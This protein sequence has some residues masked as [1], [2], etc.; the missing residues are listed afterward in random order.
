MKTRI[1]A[2]VSVI[3][4][5]AFTGTSFGYTSETTVFIDEVIVP[6]AG[7]PRFVIPVPS[8]PGDAV[9][10]NTKAVIDYSNA[11]DGY[12]MVKFTQNTRKA[13]RVIVKGPSGVSYTYIIKPGD[14]EVFPFSDGNGSYTVG[15]YE[16]AEGTKYAVANTV[17]ITVRLPNEFAP[18]LTPNQYVNFN[19]NNL[20]V[21]KAAELTNGS[22]NL[23]EKITAIYNFVIGNI[24][25]DK[26]LARTVQSG[27]L[28]DVDAVMKSKKGICFD[29]SAV[30]AAM[31]RSLG[32]PSK[33]VVGYAGEA[34]HA[35]INAY[36]K[37]TG[38]IN[39]VIFFD[40][41][42]WKLMD[43]TF[44]SSSKQSSEIMKFIGDGRNYKAKFMY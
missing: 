29:Y 43:P 23:I 15:V 1:K 2:A 22:A 24:S 12:V 30:M 10:R 25:Y 16:Q 35:W 27:Y 32:I 42:S 28:P 19:M 34:Y 13:L 26:E 8:A 41:N 38:W 7:A 17:T 37:E 9:Q 20:V 5:L 4:M 44:A 39:Q 3:L 14:F 36:S 40:G 21:H 33:L 6:L 18:F 31:L 11:E